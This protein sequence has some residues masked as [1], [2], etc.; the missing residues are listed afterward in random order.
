M[1][2]IDRSIM[3]PEE[4]T[5]KIKH[6]V[7]EKNI[8][9]PSKVSERGIL[10]NG[11]RDELLALEYELNSLKENMDYVNSQWVITE[12]II[13]SGKKWIGPIIC[14]IKKV[15]RKGSRWLLRPYFEQVTQYN[16]AVA[17]AL[18][19][20]MKIQEMLINIIVTDSEQEDNV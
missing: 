6:K 9:M 15:L 14:F 8:P 5:M 13:Y 1:F 11:M 4:L 16:G 19:D 18:C 3:S 12:P 7:I 10:M 17:K 2:E 20:S